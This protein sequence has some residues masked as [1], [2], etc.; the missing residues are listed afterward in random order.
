MNH[1]DLIILGTA[2]V[3][4][5]W[6]M[7][8]LQEHP[9]V[10]MYGEV[11]KNDFY[12]RDKGATRVCADVNM[13][14]SEAVSKHQSDPIL[15]VDVLRK[16]ARSKG[17][18]FGCKIFYTHVFGVELLRS[19]YFRDAVILH[20]YRENILDAFTSLKLARTTGKWMYEPYGDVR[21]D[22]DVEEYMTFR[23]RL[24]SDFAAWRAWLATNH[25]E[26]RLMEIAYSKIGTDQLLSDVGDLLEIGGLALPSIAKQARKPAE[27]YWIQDWAR[28]FAAD[29]LV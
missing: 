3:G 29:E 4:S 11:L 15:I 5:N 2:R 13:K 1:A 10:A 21:L 16:R 7:R 6:L 22:F 26:E 25:P 27:E 18:R 12:T 23:T 8:A 9:E 17:Q 20:M 14:M 28:D 24:R 19:G